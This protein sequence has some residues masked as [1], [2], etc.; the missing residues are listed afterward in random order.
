MTASDLAAIICA[1]VAVVSIAALVI[2]AARIDRSAKV[3]A[4]VT[5]Q[6]RVELS[7]A[8]EAVERTERA[9]VSATDQVDRLDS[10]IRTAGSVTDTA[11]AATQAA[12]RVLASPVIR[13]AAVA[14]GTRGAARRLRGRRTDR[15]DTQDRRGA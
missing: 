13:T 1:A 3:L 5:E 11:D 15:D 8:A 6:M 12:F 4:A 14:S 10:L 9:A 7:A 2:V